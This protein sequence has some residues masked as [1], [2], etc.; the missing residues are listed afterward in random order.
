MLRG[1][2]TRYLNSEDGCCIKSDE[3]EVEVENTDDDDETDLDDNAISLQSMEELEDELLETDGPRSNVAVAA[4]KMTKIADEAEYPLYDH[5]FINDVFRHASIWLRTVAVSMVVWALLFIACLTLH[6]LYMDRC[7]PNDVMG[8]FSACIMG[9]MLARYT[10]DTFVAVLCFYQARYVRNHT[11]LQNQ[12]ANTM[13]V[14]GAKLDA[15]YRKMLNIGSRVMADKKNRAVLIA[16]TCEPRRRTKPL[17]QPQLR[18]AFRHL[19]TLAATNPVGCFYGD[20]EHYK[21]GGAISLH[22]ERHRTSLRYVRRIVGA[23][24]AIPF[25]TTLFWLLAATSAMR[26]LKTHWSDRRLIGEQIPALCLHTHNF[27]W[28]LLVLTFLHSI[29]RL[30]PVVYDLLP[31][32]R[33]NRISRNQYRQFHDYSHRHENNNKVHHRTTFHHRNHGGISSSYVA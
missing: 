31:K 15:P 18:Q 11:V 32:R 24:D 10:Y 3:D 28:T 19:Q 5:R 6:F 27:Y 33:H 17:S 16:E 14:D 26:H 29:F 20:R 1:G 23:M 8:K 4:E 25:I 21:E 22:L 30:V 7:E 13:R 12:I 9:Y 2:T